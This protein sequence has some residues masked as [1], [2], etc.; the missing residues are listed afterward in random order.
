MAY[1]KIDYR[2]VCRFAFPL[3]SVLFGIWI[4][5]DKG[6]GGNNALFSPS[7]T[8]I[9]LREWATAKSEITGDGGICGIEVRRLPDGEVLLGE[10]A[11]APLIPASVTKVLTS[12]A[13]LKKLGPDHVFKTEFRGHKPQNGVITGNLF[14]S[15]NGNPLWFSRDV[16][17]C[18]ESFV[19][20]LGIKEIQG[21]VIVDQRFFM[22]SVERLCLDGKCYRSYNPTISAV[23]VD[24]NTLTITVYPGQKIGEKARVSWG[25]SGIAPIPIRNSTKT[26]PPKQKTALSFKLV[27]ESGELIGV[28]TGRISAKDRCGTTFAFKLDDPSKVIVGAVRNLLIANRVRIGQAPAPTYGEPVTLFSCRT[29]SL[30]EVLHGIN[31]HSNNFMAEMLLRHLGGETLGPPGTREKGAQVVAGVLKEIGIS[32][33]EFYLDSGSGLSYTTKASPATFGHA[34]THLYNNQLLRDPFLASLAENGRDG[35]LRRHWAGAPFRVKGKTG[36][37]AN[38]V[39]FSGYVFWSDSAPPF[40]VTYICNNVSKTWKIRHVMDNFVWRS[41]MALRKL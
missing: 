16:K 13:A 26:V 39:G 2:T 38:V 19:S 37:L 29:P 10:N 33:K 3:F 30:S 9:F 28:L 25:E 7:A 22:P 35:T 32:P 18:V 6:W 27:S 36:T 24:F 23:A 5:G 15:S 21:S 40:I 17:Y 4:G 14:I 8:Q 1:P 20:T 11:H 12:L 34:L 31:R 41:V